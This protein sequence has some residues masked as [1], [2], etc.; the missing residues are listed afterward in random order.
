MLCDCSL[1]LKDK[2]ERAFSICMTQALEVSVILEKFPKSV[3]E[4]H[5]LVLESDGGT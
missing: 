3:I 4:V 2:E 5:A 1:T